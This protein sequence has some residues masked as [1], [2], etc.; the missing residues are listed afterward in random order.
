METIKY[1]NCIAEKEKYVTINI[2]TM[3]RKV[4]KKT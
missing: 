2:K 3:N 4:K 1:K